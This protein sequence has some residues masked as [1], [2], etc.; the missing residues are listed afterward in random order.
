ML[1]G[2]PGSCK[3]LVPQLSEIGLHSA[4]ISEYSALLMEER[5]PRNV[6]TEE[7]GEKNADPPEEHKGANHPDCNLE[8]A[9]GVGRIDEDTPVESQDGSFDD[10]H[11]TRMHDLHH[12]HDLS[13]R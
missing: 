5:Q 1:L 4:Q 11:G 12:K 3:G 9:R 7:S 2:Q 10:W 6:R 13:I 8:A